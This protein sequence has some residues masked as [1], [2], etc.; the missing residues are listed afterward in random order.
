MILV[1]LGGSVI[2][3]KSKD[4]TPR[5][6]VID[7][8]TQ[9][10]AD[11]GQQCLII[12]GAGSYGHIKA[13]Q[14]CLQDG[15]DHPEYRQGIDEVQ[16]DMRKLNG[17]VVDAFHASGMPVA[18][19]PAGA[20]SVF[21]DGE[22]VELPANVFKHYVDIGITPISFGDVVVDRKR[23]VCICSGDDI[24]THLARELDIK[25]CIFV[26]SE[27]GIFS[28]YPPD[29]NEGPIPDIEH[30]Q[31]I[32]FTSMNTDVTGGMERKLELIFNITST[33]CDVTILNGLVPGRLKEALEGEKVIG[34]KIGG[35]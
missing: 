23:G 5:M 18:S 19:I 30:G 25:K 17:L 31:D 21:D 2:T 34:T 14:Y 32:E 6:D 10:I 9:E 7:R 1:K 16:M 27:D 15:I 8:L 11:S 3:D 29:E 33:G 26:T 35:S 4:M 22:L 13:K 24:M 28:H 20:I 12:H